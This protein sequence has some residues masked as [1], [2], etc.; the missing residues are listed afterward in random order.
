MNGG[1]YH[2]SLYGKELDE[3]MKLNEQLGVGIGLFQ[4]LSNVALNGIY[5]Y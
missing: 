3:S 4:G 5:I 2:Y 1:F